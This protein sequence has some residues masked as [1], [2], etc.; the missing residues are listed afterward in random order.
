MARLIVKSPYIKCG[1]GQNADGYLQYIATRERVEIIPD[2]R[3]PT[4]K[5]TQLLAKLVKDFPWAGKRIFTMAAAAITTAS[6]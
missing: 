4:N 1:T 6:P 2:D 3:P 5:Q